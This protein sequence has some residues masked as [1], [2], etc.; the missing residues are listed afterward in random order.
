MKMPTENAL[1]HTGTG[2]H[3]LQVALADRFM[4]RLV[5][6][7][8]SAPLDPDTG[9]L[10][11]KCASVHTAFMRYPIDVIYLDRSGQIV[12]CVPHLHPWRASIS[13]MRTKHTFEMVAGSIARFAIA[14]G[15]RLEHATLSKSQCDSNIK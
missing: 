6:L 12:K 9:L 4:R 11:I 13:N 8:Q 10:I 7:M 5:G 2:A 15:D 14:V 3:C 1:L